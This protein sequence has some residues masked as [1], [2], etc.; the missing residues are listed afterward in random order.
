[1]QELEGRAAAAGQTLELEQTRH[2]GRGHDFG[3]RARVVG[4]P[5]EAHAT[6]DGFLFDREEPAEATTFVAAR[7]RDELEAR[8]GREQ[9]ARGVGARGLAGL[10]RP[11]VAELPEGVTARVQ[12]DL[13]GEAACEVG[14]ACERIRLDQEL[15]ELACLAGG[16]AG[17]AS[18]DEMR[19][20]AADVRGTAAG[21]GDDDIVV[22]ENRVEAAAEAC[23]VLLL[24]GRDEGLSAASLGLRE[25]EG[26]PEGVEE[27]HDREADLG[28]QLI[29]VAGNEQADLHRAPGLQ[30]RGSGRATSGRAEDMLR[31]PG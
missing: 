18:R 25:I 12:P 9:L 19:E 1:M 23:G 24:A 2:V 11:P 6:R 21:G 13:P 10:A 3:P 29:D 27:P 17:A 28:S 20:M 8:E 4:E 7:E 16:L 22:G 30:S 15:A 14:E 26:D 31:A 5:V